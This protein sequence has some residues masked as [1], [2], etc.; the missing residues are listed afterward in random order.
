MKRQ[1]LI[2]LSCVLLLA[3]CLQGCNGNAPV[4]NGLQPPAGVAVRQVAIDTMNL[5]NPFV[6]YDAGKDLYYMTG[7]GGFLWRSGDLR[8]WEGPFDIL[9]PS[10]ASWVGENA[11]ITSPEIHPYKG[12]YYYMATFARPDVMID[13]VA[14]KPINRV[15]CEIF[16]SDSITGPYEQL[17]AETPLLAPEYMAVHPTF[18]EDELNVGYLIYNYAAEQSGDAT[19]QIIRLGKKLN[20]QIG[21]PY[22]MFRASQNPWSSATDEEGKNGF[23]PIM[24]APFMFDTRGGELGILFDTTVD[25]LSAIGVAYTEKDHGLNGPW[26]IEQE[27]L[28]TGGVGGPMMF[29]DY[30]GTL[31][32]AV[33][34]DTVVGGVKKSIPQFMK[35]DSQF[36][37][38]KVKGHYKF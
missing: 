10:A 31:V 7:D 26:H 27:P 28:L 2:Y 12:K 17:T 13:T 37:K 18:C 29:K 23:S 8:L 14:G 38:L 9:R 5:A 15:S 1:F 32:M 34:R 21:E 24:R 19:V 22:I 25:G 20:V 33:H 6:V 30:D 16:V 4:C 3:I 11:V 36:D 35:M